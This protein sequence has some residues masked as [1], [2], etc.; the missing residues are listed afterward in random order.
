VTKPT[1]DRARGLWLGQLCGDAL[2]TTLEFKDA[3]ACRAAYP[4]G[5]RDIVGAGPFGLLP[6]QVTDSELALALAR[7]LVREGADRDAIARAY[8]GWLRSEPFD[9]GE[10][11]YRAFA[12]QGA[13]EAITA[14]QLEARASKTSQANGSLMRISPLALYGHSMTAEERGA[15]ARAD[16]RLSHPHEACQEACAAY[17]EALAVALAGGGA[18]AAYHAALEVA[19]SPAAQRSGV[20]ESLRNAAQS[21]PVCDGESIGWVRVALQNAFYHA[22]HAES[23]ESGVVATVMAGGDTDT[24]ACIAGALLGALYGEGAIPERWREAVLG[25]VTPRGESYQCADARQ[26]ALELTAAAP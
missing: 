21:P 13:L 3:A 1:P 7:S 6:G 16:S 5:L 10:T 4:N 14:A 25:C 17:V 23:F 18:Q 9:C 19:S 20:T 2:G 15:M 12:Q 22:L 26:L 11:T 24:N 8:V